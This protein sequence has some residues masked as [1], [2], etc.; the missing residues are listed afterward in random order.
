MRS[1]TLE[2]FSH[3]ELIA[4]VREL[5]KENAYLANLATEQAVLLGQ[6]QIKRGNRA[7]GVESEDHL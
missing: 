7:K 6:W 1:G 2:E 5:E 4:R 3:E